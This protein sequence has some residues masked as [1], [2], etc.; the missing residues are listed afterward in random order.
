MSFRV[1]GCIWFGIWQHAQSVFMGGFTHERFRGVCGHHQKNL[2]MHASFENCL[3]ELR[4]SS[5]TSQ[6]WKQTLLQGAQKKFPWKTKLNRGIKTRKK[7]CSRDVEIKQN[8]MG[9][10]EGQK[11]MGQCDHCCACTVI[12]KEHSGVSGALVVSFPVSQVLF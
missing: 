5:V 3:L 4:R 1:E 10:C 11:L 2:E 8:T 6:E 9:I 12:G 7:S